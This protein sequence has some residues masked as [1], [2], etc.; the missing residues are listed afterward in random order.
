MKSL[1]CLIAAMAIPCVVSVIVPGVKAQDYSS[2]EEYVLKQ[3]ALTEDEVP[4]FDEEMMAE[5]AKEEVGKSE[6]PEMVE[7][8]V[9]EPEVE[10]PE[11]EEPE[12]ETPQEETPEMMEESQ[13]YD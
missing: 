8:E 5:A 13:L 10:E 3:P 1:T 7:P 6:V 11:M 12:V 9:T 2:D 4:N